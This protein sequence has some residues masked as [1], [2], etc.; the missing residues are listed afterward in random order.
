MYFD[1]G[2]LCKWIALFFQIIK[3]RC[4]LQL[5]LYRPN[6]VEILK[7]LKHD[8]TNQLKLIDQNENNFMLNAPDL[9]EMFYFIK[10]ELPHWHL[11]SKLKSAMKYQSPM[12]R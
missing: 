10:I 1:A 6:V 8:V 7:H 12:N 2:Q 11:Q 9:I 3:H 4:S 5:T